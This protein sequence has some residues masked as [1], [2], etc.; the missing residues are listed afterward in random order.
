M[1]LA[2]I[3]SNYSS[4]DDSSSDGE[5]GDNE[6]KKSK[7][8]KKEKKDDDEEEEEDGDEDQEGSRNFSRD[9]RL[10]LL[11]ILMVI[12]LLCG[13]GTQWLTLVHSP[14]NSLSKS[15]LYTTMSVLFGNYVGGDCFTAFCTVNHCATSR[16]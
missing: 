12:F 7:K 6:D 15:I 16:R 11:V 10:L 1:L 8:V 5:G 13:S 9:A 2:Q 14:S 3:K 4:G